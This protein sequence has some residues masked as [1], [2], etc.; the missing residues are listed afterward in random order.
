[1][2]AALVGGCHGRWYDRDNQ[3]ELTGRRWVLQV[4]TR[5]GGG[6]T[7]VPRDDDFTVEFDSNG[8]VSV[9]ADCNQCGG[10]YQAGEARLGISALACTRVFCTETAPFDTEF[11]EQ[12]QASHSYFVEGRLLTIR[13]DDGVLVFDR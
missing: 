13:T 7:S 2:L 1:M 12:L 11:V 4:L 9:Q 8:D 10:T 5:D 6:I 3:G